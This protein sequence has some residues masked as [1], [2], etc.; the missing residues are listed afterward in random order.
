MK[1]GMAMFEGG[2]SAANISGLK[3]HF[4][5]FYQVKFMKDNQA[6]LT[7]MSTGNSSTIR[8]AN[9]TQNVCF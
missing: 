1:S 3:A 4:P 6:S 9:K 5:E 2:L 8:Y 7:V